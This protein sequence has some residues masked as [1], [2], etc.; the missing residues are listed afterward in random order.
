[1]ELESCFTFTVSFKLVKRY[2]RNRAKLSSALLPEG[3]SLGEVVEEE[4]RCWIASMPHRFP[5]FTTSEENKK[6]HFFFFK[7]RKGR[8]CFVLF[9]IIFF[10]FGKEEYH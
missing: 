1:M 9:F 3:L 10:F 7:V 6:G 4:R 8:F 5:T 2:S